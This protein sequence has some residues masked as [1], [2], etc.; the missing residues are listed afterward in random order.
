[1][2]IKHTHEWGLAKTLKITPYPR[3]EK[4]HGE[5]VSFICHCGALKQVEVFQV[6]E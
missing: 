4:Y 5:M 6:E 2:T 1:M 3:A